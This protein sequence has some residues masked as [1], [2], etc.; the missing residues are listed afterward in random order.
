[1]IT[2]ISSFYFV[3]EIS[4]TNCTINRSY[5]PLSLIYIGEVI[6][7]PMSLGL[8]LIEAYKNSK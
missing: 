4:L 1:M 8:P 5:M 6:F 3:S 2:L 7:D